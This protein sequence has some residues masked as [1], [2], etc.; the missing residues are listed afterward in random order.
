MARLDVGR[1]IDSLVQKE[2]IEPEVILDALGVAV[3]ATDAQ[4]IITY[5][6]QAA[7]DIWGRSPELG[8]DMWCGSWRILHPDGSVMPHDSCP[9][10]IALREDRT[11]R[12]AEAIAE[13]PDG[14]RVWFTPFPTPVHDSAG[15]LIGA[16]NVLV[17]ITDRIA[18][19]AALQQREDELKDFFDNS[20]IGL[21]LVGPDGTVLRANTAEL[22][23]LG[24]AEHEYIGH[25][26]AE[27]YEDERVAE[28]VLSRL[29]RGETLH[30]YEA[31]LKCKDGSTKIVGID[32]SALW[33]DGKFIH[34][35]CFTRD[36]GEL[37]KAAET[38]ERLSAI[39][40]SS[41]DCIISKDLDGTVRSW[42]AGAQRIF[43]YTSEEMIGR[44]IRTIIPED[45]QSEEDE[46][47]SRIRRGEKVDHFET[48]RRRK[49]GTLIDIS[50]TVS[51]IKDR[52]GRIIGCSKVARD[53]TDR[54]IA[55]R[56]MQESIALKDQFLGLISHELRTPLATIYGG[57]RLLLDRFD[58]L[59]AGSRKELLRDMEEES[60]RLERII[61]NLLLMTKVDASGV[62]LEPIH[63]DKVIEAGV[64]HFQG[65]NRGR[66]VSLTVTGEDFVCSGNDT[67]MDMVLSNLLMNASKY[68][69][70]SSAIEV[71]VHEGE[72]AVEVRV[73]D[74]GI[75][76]TDAEA[77]KLFVP[78]FRSESAKSTASGVGVGLAVCKRVVDAQ[79]GS[80][81][82]LA[83]DGG[84]A[85]FGFTL[86]KASIV[87]GSL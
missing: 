20:A 78:F 86:P 39:V 38:Q 58:V 59:P 77:E 68:S 65:R 28:D 81:W 32:S 52:H 9:M 11:V 43:G 71:E 36:V 12:G 48:V 5:Y 60:L 85:E 79:G 62:D 83:R 22:E 54:K 51:P 31:R 82:A 69:D 46:V 15:Q 3:Y 44:S 41:D 7:A 2:G 47:L 57:S 14:S 50:L 18:A 66:T 87:V 4:G 67:Y 33:R 40:A 24:Y 73:L 76:F 42:N 70:E 13:R 21:H 35:R 27:F 74:R 61:Q 53:I 45:R 30:D 56:A 84:G 29:N 72:A 25:H 26:I 17:D 16:V 8:I 23:M 10:A 64:A 37:H 49:D 6:N 1:V 63:L 19:N 80:I 34:S 75:G 55:E